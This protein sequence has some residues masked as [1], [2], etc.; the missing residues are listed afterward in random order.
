MALEIHDHGNGNLIEI[1]AEALAALSGRLVLH[2]TGN[3]V[4]IA[5][6]VAATFLQ[7]ELAGG[8]S[9]AIGPHGNLGHLFVHASR[10]SSVEIGS[11]AGFNGMVRLLLHEPRRIGI[12]NAC[13]FGGETDITVSDMHSILDS[14][15]GKRINPAQ[16]VTI[17]DRVWVGQRAMI[18]KGVSIGEGSV[19]GAGSVVTRDVPAQCVAAGNPAR[20]VRRGASWDFRLV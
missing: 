6:P 7:L 2:G 1:G 5:A 9:V 3:R 17:A 4:R 8:A 11:F 14:A 13:L 19:I 18:L 15:T 10:G 20:V 12:G 16:D